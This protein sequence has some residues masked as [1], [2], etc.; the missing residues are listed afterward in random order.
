MFYKGLARRCTILAAALWSARPRRSSGLLGL[1]SIP[2]LSWEHNFDTANAWV[3]HKPIQLEPTQ[4]GWRL[5]LTHVALSNGDPP[6]STH[7]RSPRTAQQLPGWLLL[8]GRAHC[9]RILARWAAHH[10]RLRRR[11][12]LPLGHRPR[13]HLGGC[14][15]RFICH[16][17]PDLYLDAT[18]PRRACVTVNTS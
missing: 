10:L 2:H 14:W 7:Q 17:P 12:G 5:K 16:V 15:S 11:L 4:V 1:C 18:R 13:R 9:R 6:C 8:Q 3:G